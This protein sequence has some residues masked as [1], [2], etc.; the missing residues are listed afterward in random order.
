[1][2]ETPRSTRSRCVEF[3]GHALRQQLT[4]IE[5]ILG[6]SRIAAFRERL[7]AELRALHPVGLLAGGWYPIDWAEKAYAA[8]VATEPGETALPERVSREGLERDMKGIYRFLLRLVTPDMAITHADRVLS[9][10]MRGPSVVSIRKAGKT[11]Y[12]LVLAGASGIGPYMWR[13]TCAGLARLAETIGGPGAQVR[14]SHGGSAGD[15][16]S[17]LEFKWAK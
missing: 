5:E 7:P 17:T 12:T 9:T 14:V 8:A 6:A 15:S 1:M 3:K 13:D 16:K 4:I 2:D 10:Y 11:E